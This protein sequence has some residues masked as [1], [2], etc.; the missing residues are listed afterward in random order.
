MHASRALV[1]TAMLPSAENPHAKRM[2]KAGSDSGAQ[3]QVANT[4]VTVRNARC[5]YRVLMLP[6]A[7]R[8]RS[9]C[10]DLS[11]ADK[12]RKTELVLNGIVVGEMEVTGDFEKD[13]ALTIQFLKDKGLY[14]KSPGSRVS[15]DQ[16]GR[17]S[18]RE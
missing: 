10:H 9:S 13:A 18:C 1:A 6:A 5:R 15:C 11:V 16:I 4:A 2:R 14:Q 3:P 7:L 17:A 12:P 8:S